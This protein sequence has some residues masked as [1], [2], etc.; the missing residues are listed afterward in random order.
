MTDGKTIDVYTLT[1]RNG[2]QVSITNYAGRVVCILDASPL[3]RSS[4]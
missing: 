1:N 3:K 2:I 4:W